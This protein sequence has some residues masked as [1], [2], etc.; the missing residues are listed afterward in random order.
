MNNRTQELIE[1]SYIE[2]HVP[3]NPTHN[4]HIRRYWSETESPLILVSL[5]VQECCNQVRAIDAMEI[6]K[7]FGVKE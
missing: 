5:I 2:V 1:Q 3:D 7:H 6:R 4:E